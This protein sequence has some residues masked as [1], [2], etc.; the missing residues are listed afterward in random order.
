MNLRNL[1]VVS[2]L[3]LLS[4]APHSLR[5]DDQAPS[6]KHKIEQLIQR[7]ENLKD[8]KFVRNGTEYDAKT[9]AKFLKGKWDANSSKIQTAGDFITI[10]AT[11][12]TTSGKPYVIRYA[13]GR[14]VS[15]AEFLAAELKAIDAP[16]ADSAKQQPNIILIITD[17]QGYGDL[18][19]HGNPSV[20]TPNLDA[21]AAESVRLVNFH[22]SP[23]CAPTRCAL[24]TGRH[25]FR[26]GVTH[27]IN[28]RER[29]ALSATT[30]PQLLQRAGYAT[31]IFGKWHLGDEAPY[32]PD[33]RGFSEVFIHGAGGIGQSYVGSCGDAP[34]NSYFHPAV[35]H[36]G[37]F[38]KTQKYCTDVFFDQAL[39][40]IESR[41]GQGPFYA[42]IATNAPHAP[43]DCPPEY[44]ARYAHLNDPQ[45]AKF[46]GMIT[47]IDDNVGQL[48]A[49][50]KELQIE[51]DTLLIFMT[52]NGGTAGVKEFNAGMR[53]SKVTPWEGGTR[54]PCFLRWG[55][56]FPVGERTQL[57]AH[58]DMFRTLTGLAGATIPPEVEQKLE[59][60]NLLPVL[61]SPDA[62]WENRILVTHMGRWE[63]GQSA[64]AKRSQASI[65]DERF[66][67]VS[68]GQ[69]PSW[70]L[71]DL[72]NDPG[73][74]TD[75]AT[76]F[77]QDTARLERAYDAWWESIQPDFLINE[78]VTPPA[79]NTFHTLYW[80]QFPDERP[81][82]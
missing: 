57:T 34:Q 23:T 49:K 74:R 8:A 16:Q 21:L 3:G 18:A 64:A 46:Y 80:K 33:R 20:K 81:K 66:T 25:E 4:L 75:V 54:V 2:I 53:G 41:R 70:Q 12:S 72:K 52:D 77:P 15:S 24:M 10:A 6:E 51:R 7:V 42:H 59:G 43:L 76:Q 62:P 19:C 82:K 45:R 17:D 61:N 5:A 37:T 29:M 28:E 48:R 31:G 60:R 50:L 39:T 14:E 68:A 55:D 35:L 13:D 32:Q 65:R 71:F 67:L 47:N 38:V 11:K 40:W 22:V 30:F 58:I 26:S 56:R 44:E 73:Q 36:N 79:E 78:T 1:M 63:K 27:T 9:A 69:N